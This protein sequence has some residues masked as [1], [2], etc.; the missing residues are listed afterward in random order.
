M[1]TLKFSRDWSSEPAAG[2][3]YMP[4]VACQGA[5]V[6]LYDAFR[7]ILAAGGGEHVSGDDYRRTGRGQLS[8]N[9]F[10]VVSHCIVLIIAACDLHASI[11]IRSFE[12]L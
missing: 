6:L 3:K 10:S 12:R 2:H 4:S 7:A 1:P 5:H 8:S 11:V 9:S